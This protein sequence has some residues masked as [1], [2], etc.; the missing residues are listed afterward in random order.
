[1]NNNGMPKIMLDY[2]PSR[3]RRLERRDY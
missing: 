2:R 1:M 3:R